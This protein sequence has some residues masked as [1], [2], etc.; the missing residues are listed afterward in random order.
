M[1]ENPGSFISFYRETKIMKKL[2]HPDILQLFSVW[3]SKN[4]YYMLIQYCGG[5]T[6]WDKV[7]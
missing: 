3:E 6:L 2:K 5:G 1:A 4:S 7:E